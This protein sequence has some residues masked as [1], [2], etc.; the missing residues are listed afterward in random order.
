MKLLLQFWPWLRFLIGV[1]PYNCD[2]GNFRSTMRDN[3]NKQS[4][5]NSKTRAGK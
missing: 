1:N 2:R 4:C 5:E 3:P